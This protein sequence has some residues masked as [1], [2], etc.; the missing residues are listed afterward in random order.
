M[1]P[2]P[3][4]WKHFLAGI[5]IVAAGIA[6]TPLFFTHVYPHVGGN[7]AQVIDC[8][9]RTCEERTL[10]RTYTG[11]KMFYSDDAYTPVLNDRC[12]RTAEGTDDVTLVTDAANH[13]TTPRTD[14][15]PRETMITRRLAGGWDLEFLPDGMLITQK[16]GAVLRYRDG[17]T[18]TLGKLDVF[19]NQNLG[20]MGAAV[21][22]DFSRN[23]Y[24]YLYYAYENVGHT[25]DRFPKKL[26]SFKFYV[27][28]R[29][30]R[31]RLVNG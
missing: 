21:D 8:D 26:P 28:S 2:G 15:P 7:P 18:T 23:R 31:F 27:K 22:P 14:T 1:V 30:S 3:L 4:S 24:I 10:R 11:C 29:I 19:T 25:W 16:D 17:N 6:A 20:L 12:N 5:G 9:E 13:I